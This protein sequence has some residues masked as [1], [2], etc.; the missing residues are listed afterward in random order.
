VSLS[1]L[2]KP[3]AEERLPAFLNHPVWQVRMYAARAAASLEDEVALR[4][5]AGDPQDNVREAAVSVLSRVAGHRVDDIY[6]AALERPDYQLVMT[7]A[8]A[9]GGSPNREG[10][11][12]ALLA[13]LARSPPR[14][15]TRR[16]T[17]VWRC[18]SRARAGPA[19]AADTLVPTS[20][21]ST[22]NR[23]ACR[24]DPHGVD[25]ISLT[26]RRRPSAIV[27]RRRLQI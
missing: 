6:L 5:L 26:R 1:R 2:D 23:P 19:A 7:A 4:H 15:A 22:A 16:A 25:G 27:G 13:A 3:R 8:R 21:I 20:V 24:R 17:R 14:V 12:P 9:L 11:V 10:A 18:S